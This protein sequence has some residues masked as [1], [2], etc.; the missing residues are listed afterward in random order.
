M[1]W[2]GSLCLDAQDSHS[3]LLEAGILWTPQIMAMTQN[4]QVQ[5]MVVTAGSGAVCLETGLPCVVMAVLEL[6]L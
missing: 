5:R 2:T 3:L 1:R 6:P 4:K